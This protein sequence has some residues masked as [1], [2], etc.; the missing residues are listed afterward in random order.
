MTWSQS[1]TFALAN[2]QCRVCQGMGALNG[3]APFSPTNS[4][5]AFAAGQRAYYDAVNEDA[6]RS[7]NPCGCVLRVIFRAC[8]DRFRRCSASTGSIRGV[9]WE[10][11]GA[12]Q[13][14][15]LSVGRRNEERS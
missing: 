14:R 11:I 10:R 7:V 1:E 15:G 3:A 5:E 13:N 9:Q 4:A 12:A 8:L 2:R 6:D